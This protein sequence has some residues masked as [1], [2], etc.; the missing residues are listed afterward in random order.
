MG[1]ETEE[2]LEKAQRMN[3]LAIKY[4][5]ENQ[6]TETLKYLEFYKLQIEGKIFDFKSPYD[7][8]IVANNEQFFEKEFLKLVG[9]D[10]INEIKQAEELVD[11][12]IYY[13]TKIQ[14]ELDSAFFSKKRKYVASAISDYYDRVGMQENLQNMTDQAIIASLDTL[15]PTGVFK[16]HGK[17]LIINEFIP[18]YTSPNL[19]KGEAIMDADKKL[20]KYI[21]DL[22]VIKLSDD[23][24][25]SGTYFI[26]Y[27]VNGEKQE[28][29]FNYET[30]KWQYMMCYT[31]IQNSFLTKELSKYMPPVLFKEEDD[32]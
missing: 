3:N 4:A 6:F 15:N 10:S 17:I 11:H 25:I 22:D 18:V 8:D 16:W 13:S 19:K 28:F 20:I 31:N 7:L 14:C 9:S 26:P 24:K 30:K 32:M 29:V 12:C 2:E 27:R 1:D 21:K 23:Y 5:T